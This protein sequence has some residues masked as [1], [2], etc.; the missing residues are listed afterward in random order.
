MGSPASWVGRAGPLAGVTL[1]TPGAQGARARGWRDGTGS[2]AFGTVATG[3][4]GDCDGASGQDRAGEERLRGLRSG[5]GP[6]GP[7]V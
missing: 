7:G 1:R 6:N 4:D 5:Y 3:L 2:W